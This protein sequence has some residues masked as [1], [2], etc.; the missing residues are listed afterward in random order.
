MAAGT[1]LGTRPPAGGPGEAAASAVSHAYPVALDAVRAGDYPVNRQIS[2]LTP[3]VL[4]LTDIRVLA[5]GQAEFLVQYDNT[6]SVTQQLTC[7]GS[8]AQA[9]ATLTLAGGQTLT[10]IADYCSQ[11]PDQTAIY[12][13]AG[14]D[15]PSY[16]IFA[17]SSR[18]D[19][20]FT[21]NWPAGD[22]S[23]TVGDLQLPG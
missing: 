19:R 20:P 7:S 11:H 23:G 13:G 10:S 5:S 18:L 1:F 21:L 4:T 6:S 22:L 2:A 14:Q 15:L 17:D 3:W 16:T 9:K 12:V 8:A